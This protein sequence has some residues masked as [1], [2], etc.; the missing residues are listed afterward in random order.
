VASQRIGVR[1]GRGC[2]CGRTKYQ[3]FARHFFKTDLHLPRVVGSCVGDL[4]AVIREA[5]EKPVRAVA[6]A[7]HSIM[8][9]RAIRINQLPFS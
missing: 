4:S 8:V 6:N 7:R 5:I 2:G 9:L 1:R 3:Q